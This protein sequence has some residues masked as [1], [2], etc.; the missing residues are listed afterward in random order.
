M[1]VMKVDKSMVSSGMTIGLSVRCSLFVLG[2][3]IAL[4]HRFEV[5]WL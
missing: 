4:G 1:V 2:G 5:V 3:R